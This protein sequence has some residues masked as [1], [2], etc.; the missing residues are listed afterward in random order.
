MA[1]NLRPFKDFFKSGQIGGALLIV[2]V[3]VSLTIANAGLYD[4]FHS[5]LNYSFGYAPLDL[6]YTTE[7]WINDGLM[8]IFFLLV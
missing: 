5:L 3:M 8:A 4:E 7:V 6:K 1:I 2:S